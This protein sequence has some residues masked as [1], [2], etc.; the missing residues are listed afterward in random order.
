MR[1]AR[2]ETGAGLR[3]AEVIGALSL[4]TDLAMGQPMAFALRSCV[5]AVRLGEALG[6]A[7]DRLGEIYY[8]ALLRY[9]GCNAET[10]VMAAM[11]GDELALRKDFAVI[12]SADVP[13]VLRL[14]AR[15]VRRANAGAA[16]LTMVRIIAQRL[17]AAQAVTQAG[18]AGHCEVAQRLGE[19]LGFARPVIDA[20]GQLYERW[21]GK[22]LPNGL[23]GDAIALAVRVVSPV[24]DALAVYDAEG[25]AA[26]VAMV[27]RRSGSAYDPRVADRLC[28]IAPA[29]FER[30]GEEPSW[31]EVLALEPEPRVVLSDER[32]DEACL[33]MADFAD[34]KS[35]FSLG[36]SRA[37]A[38]LAERAA[39]SYGLSRSDTNALRRAA[40]LHDIGGV[41]ISSAIWCKPGPLS[42]SEWERVRLH[43]YY[44]ERI[45][46]GS[47]PLARLGAIAAHHHERV[48]GSGYH[49]AVHSA[50]TP[51]A[52]KLLGAAD[53][54]QAMLEPRPHRPARSADDAAAELRRD[55]R[56]GTLDADAVVAVLDAAGHR[57]PPRRAAV[58][59][60]TEREVDV[61]RLAA[62]AKSTKEIARE[63]GISAK[64]ADNHIQNVYGKIGV[65][66]RAGA[67]LF[68]M[69]HALLGP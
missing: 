57:V 56:N 19:R 4:A 26:A 8:Q 36:H 11:F 34:I 16:P 29:F 65:S 64:T 13:G 20:L 59:G 48:D 55:V 35:P 12:D 2:S 41:A 28:A 18:F 32:F 25:A 52:A 58:A 60:L 37:V 22:G 63:L 21:D 43:A 38:E 53:A 69:E 14:L 68:A 10:H 31:D 67:T 47:A 50:G 40:L 33:A 23:R 42:T 30:L 66:T 15:H 7:A 1:Q 27:R 61:L 3:L 17:L 9:V 5:L 6:L 44:T 45:L 51:A 24:Q 62:R 49:R 39:E 54:Y 46:A